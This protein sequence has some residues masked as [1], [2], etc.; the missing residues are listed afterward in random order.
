M[1][2]KRKQLEN[3]EITETTETNLPLIKRMS[4]EPSPKKVSK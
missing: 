4:D 1:T 3:E 2:K